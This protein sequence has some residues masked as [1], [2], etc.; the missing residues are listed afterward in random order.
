[1]SRR[2]PGEGSLARRK[3]GRWQASLQV[4]GHRRTVYGKTRAECATKLAD[5][6]RQ[7]AK[8]GILPNPGKRTLD[9]LLDAWLETEASSLKPRTLADYQGICDRHLSPALGTVRLDRLTPHRIQRLYTRYL[10]KGQSRTA[11]KCHR[12]LSQALALAV[13]WGWLAHN[14]CE[15]VDT[16]QHRYRR[17]EP[18]TAGE[19]RVFLGGTAEHWLGP[20]WLFLAVTGCRLGEALALEWADVDLG[21]G[22][23]SVT[24]SVQRIK[25]EWVVSEP[26]TRASIRCITLP[27]EGVKALRRQAEYRLAHG[28]GALVFPNKGGEPLNRTTVAHAMRVACGRLGLP[29]LSPHGLR[30]LHASLLLAEGLPVPQVTRRLGHAN[31]AITMSVY[32]HVLEADDRQTTEALKRALEG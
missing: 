4:D 8:A 27:P 6:Q 1:M 12:L 14:P 28:G 19:L 30:H 9:Y 22:K 2:S 11:L 24:K 26:K 7:V 3:D 18:W 29:H 20:L 17:Q 32:A 31:S 13:R 16:P 21:S 15:R 10:T 5:L 23:V 25:G